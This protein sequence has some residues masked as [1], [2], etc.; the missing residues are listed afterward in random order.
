MAD[1]NL[2]LQWTDDQWNRVRQV[3]YEEA[4]KARVA[5]NVLPLYGPLDPDATYVSK[6][7]L[8]YDKAPS[9]A[10]TSK[11]ISVNNQE[12]WPLLTLQ[13]E[14]F[15]RGA[16]VADPEL[17]S[18]LAAFRRAA[19]I[20]ARLEDTII[21]N[22]RPPDVQVE[23]VRTQREK[24][25]EEEKQARER[26]EQTHQQKVA[27]AT[28]PRDK[29][30]A[31]GEL[32]Q[33]RADLEKLTQDNKKARESQKGGLAGEKLLALPTVWRVTGAERMDGL[34][35]ETEPAMS[36]LP[37]GQGTQSLGDRL[38]GD[39]AGAIGELEAAGHLGPFACV[40]D[41]EF[42]K[43]V[44]TPNRGS[45]VL[46]QDR[47][48]PF[49][50]GGP[51]LRTSTLPDYTGLVIASAGAPIDLVVATDISVSFLQ[52]TLEPRFVFRVYEK[53][54]LRIKEKGAVIRL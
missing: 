38:V 23:A 9:E 6:E 35:D 10:L 22:G 18:A 25:L 16:Q 30:I 49:L 45:L 42:F 17:S 5:G 14:V 50:G 48:L 12:T 4:R 36:Q 51:L 37:G 33:G 29:E 19:N 34:L 21:F 1:S 28:A 13:I 3:V 52:V 2:Q 24:D 32:K 40:L 43:A 31:D 27:R 8:T 20:L 11:R 39:I 41:Q 54:A 46:P 15:L 44:Q 7:L 53:I 47:I 26:T